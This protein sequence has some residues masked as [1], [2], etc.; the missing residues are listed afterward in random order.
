MPSLIYPGFSRFRDDGGEV[1]EVY[2]L[3]G[4]M[5][6]CRTVHDFEQLRSPW[7]G[8]NCAGSRRSENVGSQHNSDLHLLRRRAAAV[9]SRCVFTMYQI[10]AQGAEVPDVERTRPL[11]EADAAFIA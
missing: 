4:E 11:R 2:R 8:I 3:L 5:P 9:A 6:G 1:G 7:C 10:M